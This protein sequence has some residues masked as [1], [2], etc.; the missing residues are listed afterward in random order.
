MDTR[1]VFEVNGKTYEIVISAGSPFG[2]H[3]NVENKV[4]RAMCWGAISPLPGT[5]SFCKGCQVP[6]WHNDA[7]K[8]NCAA[9]MHSEVPPR[10]SKRQRTNALQ[11]CRASFDR[12][13]PAG[14]TSSDIL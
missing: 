11:D 3:I 4:P 6:E 8:C 2:S 12:A 10:G 9:E 7:E 1:E 13:S 14:T 5:I